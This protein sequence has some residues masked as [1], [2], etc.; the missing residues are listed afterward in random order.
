MPETAEAVANQK[1]T[2]EHTTRKLEEIA[3]RIRA[4]TFGPVV[5]DYVTTDIHGYTWVEIKDVGV[6]QI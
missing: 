6:R 5:R 3:A 1:S 2:S 4:R